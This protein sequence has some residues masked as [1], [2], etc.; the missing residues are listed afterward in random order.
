MADA[1]KAQA[2]AD[3]MILAVKEYFARAFTANIGPLEA[4]IKRLEARL[5][6][7]ERKKK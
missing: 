1:S 5:G 3:R 7:L 2:L 4:R 6:A